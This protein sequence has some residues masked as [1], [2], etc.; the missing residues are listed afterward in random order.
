VEAHAHVSRLRLFLP[1][2]ERLDAA[3]PL[4]WRLLERRG[5]V[6]DGRSTL[7]ELPGADEVEAILPAS[8]VLFAR[9]KLPR[10]SDATIRELLPFAVEDRLLADPAQIHAVAGRT[11]AGGDT[12]VAVVD[13]AWLA[14]V[15]RALDAAG[16]KPRH[17]WC[18]S[19][20][21]PAVAGAWHVVLHGASGLLVDE[22]GTASTFDWHAQGS[23]PLAIRVALDEATTRG[24]RPRKLLVH[25][26]VVPA[27]GPA[28]SPRTTSA[29][30]EAWSAEASV[31]FERSSPWPELE[32]SAPA[33]GA[34][35][36]L[37]GD[38]APR[39]TGVSSVRL[40]RA[41]IALAAVIALLQFGFTAV[42]TWRLAR[43]RDALEARREAIFRSAFPDARVVVDPDLQMARNLA[44]LR[45]ARGL[46]S[47]DEFL[48]KL[49]QAA[50]ESDARASTIDY[51]TGRLTVTRGAKDGGAR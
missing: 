26:G 5:S 20:L 33:D 4:R 32:A 37:A 3:G 42:D 7:A 36:L 8:R 47:G 39:R 44:Q 24:Q 23:L 38:F 50:R 6:R 10:V 22:A 46:A 28:T 51:A 1:E 14:A 12:T 31:P 17:A 11:D 16:R 43:E 40:P 13:R 21:V 45:A 9:L 19:A 34:I 2:S 25:E 15:L 30:F 18:E 35:D 27:P 29:P 41:A 49:T 48:V